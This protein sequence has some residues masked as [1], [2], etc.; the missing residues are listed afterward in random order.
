MNRDYQILLIINIIYLVIQSKDNEHHE[1]LFY[2][3]TN[4][5]I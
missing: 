2:N 4:I 1:H 5:T 3:Y